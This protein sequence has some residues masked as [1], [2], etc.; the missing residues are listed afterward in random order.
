MHVC[1][2]RSTGGNKVHRTIASCIKPCVA[3]LHNMHGHLCKEHEG[4]LGARCAVFTV[5]FLF[6]QDADTLCPAIELC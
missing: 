2:C 5:H 4:E 6:W 3:Q 1:T